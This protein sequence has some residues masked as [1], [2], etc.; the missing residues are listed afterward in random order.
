M[1]M[2]IIKEEDYNEVSKKVH[3]VSFDTFPDEWIMNPPGMDEEEAQPED[4]NGKDAAPAQPAIDLMAVRQEADQITA[5]ARQEA[6]QLVAQ[7]RQ[8]ADQFAA[9]VRQEAENIGAQARQEA[10]DIKKEAYASGFSSGE[11][12]GYKKGYEDGYTKGKA[13]ALEESTN[14]INMINKVIGGLENYRSEILYEAR[15]DIVKMA[16][17]VA[18][19]VLHKEIMTDPQTV[20][21]VV[22]H[23]ISKVG[24]K[25]KFVVHVNPLDVEVLKAAGSEIAGLIDGLESLKFKP[26]PKVEAGGCVVQTESGTVDAQVDRQYNEIKESVLE[27]IDGAEITQEA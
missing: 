11:E 3:P 14:S 17:S 1:S 19:K 12:G 10:E 4:G 25:K 13:T 15:N 5:Q 8:E 16:V 9:Q 26:D 7:A 6:E 22:K 21:S 20:V 18:E 2:R 24:F 27:N 23:A